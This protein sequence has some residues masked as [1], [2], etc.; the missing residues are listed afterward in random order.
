MHIDSCARSH[1]YYLFGVY[2]SLQLH[3]VHV[4]TVRDSAPSRDR[5][6]A[7][8]RRRAALLSFTA[9]AMLA[10]PPIKDPSAPNIGKNG[11]APSRFAVGS[12]RFFVTFF[13]VVFFFMPMPILI[14]TFITAQTAAALSLRAESLA[15]T[16]PSA[17]SAS[18]LSAASL[19][20][21]SLLREYAMSCSQHAASSGFMPS[22]PLASRFV[23]R[24]PGSQNW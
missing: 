9:F 5:D 10:T 15:M 24:V 18:I 20:V 22:S 23:S 4:C 14:L 12:I 3:P 2:F 6:V 17:L 19:S 11:T 1:F 21:R 16:R 8:L 7:A 13:F